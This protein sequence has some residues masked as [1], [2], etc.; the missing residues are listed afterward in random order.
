MLKREYEILKYIH[1]HPNCT[2]RT[3]LENFSDLD[4]YHHTISHY[5]NIE[6]KLDEIRSQKESELYLQAEKNGLPLS[7]RGDYVREHMPDFNY[8]SSYVFYKTDFNF[9]EY[10]EKKQHDF[11]SFALPYGITTLIAATSVII[12][13]VNLCS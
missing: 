2:K 7:M 5:C 1:T 10:I 8:D 12:Q 6:D 9:Q 13:L 3:L 11:W 4:T